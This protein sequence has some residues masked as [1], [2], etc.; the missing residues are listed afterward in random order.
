MILK[1]SWRLANEAIIGVQAKAK[2]IVTNSK[3]AW[4]LF[5]DK[6]NS[7]QRRECTQYTQPKA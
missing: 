5:N 3:V 1:S 2:K 4:V 6:S 7:H